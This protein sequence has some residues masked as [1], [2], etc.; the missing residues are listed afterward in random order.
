MINLY[1]RI[2]ISSTI[3]ILQLLLY[4]ANI[5]LPPNLLTNMT[6]LYLMLQ[7]WH[8]YLNLY[9]LLAYMQSGRWNT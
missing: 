4:M 5:C 6:S 7:V 8:V 9:L 2:Y 1:L 3:P